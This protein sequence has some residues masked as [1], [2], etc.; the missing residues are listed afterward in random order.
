[1]QAI[2]PIVVA[3]DFSAAAMRAVRRGAM[4]AKQL[5][6]EMHLLHVVS[7]LDLYPGPDHVADFRL[8][9]EQALHTAVKNRLDALA[10]SLRK[11]FAIPVASAARI[12]RAHKEIA[13]YAAAKAAGL[14]V[15][16]A[17]GENTLLDLMMGSTASRLLR[18]AACPVLIVKNREIEPYQSAITAVDFSPGSIN[19]LELTRTV[20]PGARIEVL[21]VYDTDHD[22]RM[23][24]AGMDETFILDR[25]AR[26]LKDAEARLDLELAELKDANITRNVMAAYPA[27]AICK[28]AIK[29]DADLIVLGRHGKSGMEELL[30]GSV[31]KDVA[32]AAICD[33]LLCN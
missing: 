5:G 18:L 25:Q 9:H 11:D 22:D 17:R 1:M 3:T 4:I 2:T 16:G 14:V 8:N 27:A 12:G 15:T 21:H 29:L 10:A 26:I 6:A 19:A 28:R 13:E 30:L 33:V 20:A 31:S 32:S 24:Q 7:P 23:R